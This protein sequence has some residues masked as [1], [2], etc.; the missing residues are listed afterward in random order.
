METGS[1]SVSVNSLGVAAPD[2]AGQE[3]H[4]HDSDCADLTKCIGYSDVSISEIYE[5]KKKYINCS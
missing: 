4:S 1:G 2:F 5:S 3:S